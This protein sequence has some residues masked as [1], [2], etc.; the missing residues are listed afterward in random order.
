M[1]RWSVVV[2]VKSDCRVE[3]VVE[4]ALTMFKTLKISAV[5]TALFAVAVSQ[6]DLLTFTGTGSLDA[7]PSAG[8]NANLTALGGTPD[9]FSFP[10]GLLDF[11]TATAGSVKLGGAVDYLTIAFTGTVSDLPGLQALSGIGTV[12]GFGTLAKYS[13]NQVTITSNSFTGAGRTNITSVIGD[14]KAVP[15]PASIGAISVGLVALMRR[16]KNA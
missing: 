11:T 14:L 2:P 6:A 5:M 9:A 10:T 7:A 4:E 16:R 13:G 12:T 3:S 15:E 1:R 8:G